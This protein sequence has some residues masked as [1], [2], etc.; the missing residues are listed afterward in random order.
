MKV[1]ASPRIYMGRCP[2][3]CDG[4]FPSYRQPSP[5]GEGAPKGRIGHRRYERER[6]ECVSSTS[7]MRAPY[8]P[9]CGPPSPCGEGLDGATLRVDFYKGRCQNVCDGRFPSYRQPSPRGE[10]APK[11]RIGHRRYERERGECVSSTSFMRAP[12]PPLC[13]PPSP[14][15]E[16]LDGATLRVDFYKG[17]CQNVCDGRFPS[18]RQPSP[19]GEGAPKG[20]IG[21]RRYE[22]ERGNAFQVRRL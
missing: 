2:K 13:G 18:Y 11:G 12:Y 3:V 20:R 14:C 10:G 1:A 17:R 22:R 7:F 5:R 4:R 15:G 8:P 19:R 21:H 9:L 6:G 16:G